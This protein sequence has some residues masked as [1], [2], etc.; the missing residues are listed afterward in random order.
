MTEVYIV[1]G[2]RTPIGKANGVFKN[3]S[4]I[5]LAA[6]VLKELINRG[7]INNQSIDEVILG[8]TV[9]AGL[10]QNP[11]RQ[12][13]F[14]AGC[15]EQIPA[16]TINKVCGSGLKSVIL[17]AQS[18]LCGDADVI[19]AGGTE[20]A[21]GAPFLLPRSSKYFCKDYLKLQFIKYL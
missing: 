2:I 1:D 16:F 5:D 6:V 15:S 11:A 3:L 4:A 20:S 9:S 21:S 10:G 14:L 7:K 13:L 12:A 19:I 18:I 8:N 17:A